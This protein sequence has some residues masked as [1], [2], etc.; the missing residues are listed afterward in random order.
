MIFQLKVIL[1]KTF[2][3]FFEDLYDEIDS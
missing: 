1:S 2:T 3:P